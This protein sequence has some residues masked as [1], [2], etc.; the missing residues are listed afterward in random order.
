MAGC[1]HS[2]L[3][4]RWQGSLPGGPASTN[5]ALELRSDGT[6]EQT[7]DF[8]GQQLTRVGTY[9]AGGQRLVLRT[10]DIM[11]N[12]VS[13]KDRLDPQMA[14]VMMR[15]VTLSYET[16]GDHLTLRLG[17]STGTLDRVKQ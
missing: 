3:V 16:N 12:G 2:E 7:V 11:T 8:M 9:S 17:T 1:S 15:D 10:N 4:G 14:H 6:Y 5:G 13:V